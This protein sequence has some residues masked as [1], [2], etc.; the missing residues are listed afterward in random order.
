MQLFFFDDLIPIIFLNDVNMK[1]ILF[2][3]EIFYLTLVKKYLNIG[4]NFNI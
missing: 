4:Y 1:M 3:S 2:I